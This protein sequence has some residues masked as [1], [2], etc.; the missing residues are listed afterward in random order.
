V[1]TYGGV[2]FDEGNGLAVDVFND[3]YM[4]GRYAATA[5]FLPGDEVLEYDA[6]SSTDGF[7]LGLDGN[8]GTLNYVSVLGTIGGARMGE[9][10]IDN[11]GALFVSGR[12]G[13]MADFDP[14]LEIN[15][16][17]TSVST[18]DHFNWKLGQC[19][20]DTVITLE[21]GTLIASVIPEASYQW[22]TCDEPAMPVDG[23]SAPDFTPEDDGFYFVEIALGNCI[24]PSECLEVSS[25]SVHESAIA[26]SVNLFPNPA[27][28]IVHLKGEGIRAVEFYDMTGKMIMASTLSDVDI[29]SLKTGIYLVRIQ[30]FDNTLMKRLVIAR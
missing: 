4:N 15:S 19:I 18:A 12:F 16:G 22:F 1:Y 13:G 21:D 2:S 10:T 23:A 6:P 5:D 17:N 24:V 28:R 25:L 20:L 11:T 27:N 8:D 7:I 26:E 14:D 3:V 30:Q 9:L 29:S